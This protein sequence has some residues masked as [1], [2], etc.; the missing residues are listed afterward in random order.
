MSGEERWCVCRLHCHQIGM[1]QA[2]AGGSP[3]RRCGVLEP[4][5]DGGVVGGV[6]PLA[7]RLR[8]RSSWLRSLVKPHPVE[9]DPLL[10]GM[11]SNSLAA[12]FA[13]ASLLSR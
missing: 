11:T 9:D 13:A 1:H 6:D 3:R 8:R 12:N 7:A 2:L 10:L 4:D 5:V